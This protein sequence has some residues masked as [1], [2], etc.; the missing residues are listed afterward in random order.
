MEKKR[1]KGRR[2]GK[3]SHYGYLILKETCDLT[4]E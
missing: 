3:R 2:K 1:E 4:R